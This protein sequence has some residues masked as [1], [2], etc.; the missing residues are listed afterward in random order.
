M[1]LELENVPKFNS[2]EYMPPEDD[3]RPVVLFYYGGRE[4]SSP[5]KFW[6][7]WQKL[8]T[9]YLEKFIGNSR[10]IHDAAFQAIGGETDPEKKLRKLYAR[11]QQIRNL[12][13]E[14]ERTEQE[15]K[16][17]HLKR[18]MTAQEVL[19]RG[20]GTQGEIDALFTA[21]ARSAGF[22]ATMLGVSDRKERSFNKLVL[23]LG[24]IRSSA[25]LVKLEGKELFLSPGTRFA[26][27]GMLRWKNTATSAL[28]FSKT[29][30]F[31]TT[32]QP[33]NSPMSRTARV[34]LATD[35]SLSGEIIVEYKGEDALEHRLEALDEDEA[36]RRQSLE[37]EVKTWLPG[38]TIVKLQSSQGWES[39]DL[40]L[41]A[42]FKVQ[43]PGFASFTG[44]RMM[45]PAF[46][47]PTLQKNMFTSHLR[48]YPII[49]PY[50]FTEAD[51][52]YLELPEGYTLEEPPYR[53]KAGLSYAGYEISTVL[54]ERRLVTRR[55]L[56]FDGLQFPSDN[57]EELTEFFYRRIK[58]LNDKGNRFADVEVLVP[59]EGSISGLKARTVHPDGKII[60]FAGK[61]YQK[62]LLKGRGIK[63]LARTFTM[64]DVTVGSIIEY[65]YKIDSPG[66]FTDNYWTIQ[67]ELYTVKESFRMKPFGG[68]LEGFEKG[69][70]VAAL[71]SRM[72]NNLK[73]RQKGSGY[74]LEVENMPPFE[75][76]NY[77]PPE[78]D[79][80]P[81]VRVFYG[82]SEIASAD[83]FWR[84]AGRRWNDQAE[85]FI[86]KRREIADEALRVIGG[87]MDAI[88]KLRKLYA[89]AQ[90]IRNLSYERERTAQEDK[91]E[92]LKA[93][94]N[95]GDVLIQGYGDRDDIGRFFVALARGAGFEASLLHVSNRKE[96]FFDRGLLSARQL[97]EEIAG[98]HQDGQDIF[99]DPGTRF[100]PFGF[101]RWMHTSSMALKLDKDGGSFIKVPAAGYDKAMVRRSAEMVL[102]AAGALQRTISARFE[103]R[104]GPERRL[105]ALRTDV[106]GRTEE[107]EDEAKGWLPPGPLVKLIKAEG[108]E[109][110]EGP[111]IATFAVELPAYAVAAG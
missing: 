66:V 101:V 3:F 33:E 65:K 5:E 28:K 81:Q 11:A 61:P 34:S 59:P 99:L 78:D 53:R 14:R 105:A 67:H 49:F 75:S 100:C 108:L 38:N 27:F 70:Q 1:E 29:G 91:K 110:S 43:I 48:H 22:E 32:P 104:E 107:L 83:K 9:E 92:N 80:K 47:F 79:Y 58:V 41:V 7:E 31:I 6:E 26:P 86:G 18:N 19:Q 94:Q 51:E 64:P 87:E 102:D 21:M 60:E 76:E 30:E 13:Y 73:P 12:S 109:E 40:S 69:H 106:A 85:R 16:E 37:D 111:L 77:M 25:V 98:V 52:L 89:R 4:M 72:P 55:K 8:I 36:G 54:E 24:Q 46:F 93:N 44:K 15:R 95:A 90:Q 84:D 50:P 23:W 20:Y 62:T 63:V 74:E 56:R 68:L 88:K 35:G 45:A 103:G 10:E 17:E 82:G 42:Q 71:S 97:A 39:A 57:Y 2:E 96:R